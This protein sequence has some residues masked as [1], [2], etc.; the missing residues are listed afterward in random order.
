MPRQ[1]AAPSLWIC[2]CMKVVRASIFCIRYMPTLRVPVRGSRVITAGRVMNGCRVARPAVLDRQAVEIGLHDDVL[3][4]PLR[5]LFGSESARR[6]SLP[7]PLTF[8]TS[9]CGGCIS[10]TCW[11]FAATCVERRLAEGEAHAPFGAE[12]VDEERVGRAL[13]M[14][15]EERRAPGL[16]RPVDDLRRLEVGVDLRRDLDQLTLTAKQV[17]SSRAGRRRARPES[18]QRPDGA[19]SRVP[20]S[21]GRLR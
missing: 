18:T 16:H 9:P 13:R 10:I 12:L 11:S 8:S 14:P 5:T 4:G 19:R 15:E 3:R 1:S 17:R 20:Y 2:Q 6:F 21:G 7:S